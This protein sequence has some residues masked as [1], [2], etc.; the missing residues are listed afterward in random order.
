MNN[1]KSVMKQQRRVSVDDS[2]SRDIGVITTFLI[3][4]T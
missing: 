4:S 2:L 1:E 3:N